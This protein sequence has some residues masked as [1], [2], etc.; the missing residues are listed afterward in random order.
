V[1]AYLTSTAT[2]AA[3]PAPPSAQPAPT[4]QPR[5]SVSYL[6]DM[7]YTLR[8]GIAEGRM[9]FIGVGGTIEGQV[10]P[11][12]SA[13]E[14]QVVQITLINGEGAEH[15]IVFPDQNARSPRIT[16]RGASTTLG[17]HAERAGDFTY[18]CSVPGHEL[19]GMRGQFLVTPRPP[20]QTVVEAVISREAPP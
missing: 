18:L 4:P 17:F 13:A 15:D 14:G 2:A 8:S 12:L 20:A 9:V 16:G 7:R 5:A 11:V 3:A 19:A 1:I 10:N 6:P